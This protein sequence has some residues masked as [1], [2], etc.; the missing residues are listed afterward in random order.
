L[1]DEL[2]PEDAS[3]VGLDAFLARHGESAPAGE[4]ELVAGPGVRVVRLDEPARAYYL[5]PI[6][7]ASGLRGILQ[8]DP[9]TGREE[10]SARIRDPASPFLLSEADALAAA[11]RARPDERDW[12]EPYLGWRPSK[13]SF[14]GMRPLWV[15]PYG[16]R[17][18]YVDQSGRAFEAL[19]LS[20]RGG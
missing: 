20:G 15:V 13:E 18:V 4:G 3:R 17:A 2:S 19:T 16:D 1:A 11:R 14:D 12:G 9:R 8:V 5:V 6:R 10:A 7:D